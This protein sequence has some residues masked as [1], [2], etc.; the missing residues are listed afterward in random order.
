MISS[1]LSTAGS[2]RPSRDNPAEAM[3]E[4]LLATADAL[5]AAGAANHAEISRGLAAARSAHEDGLPTDLLE[6]MARAQGHAEEQL[7]SVI[8]TLGDAVASTLPQPPPLIPFAGKLIAPTTF[9]EN[10]GPIGKLAKLLLSPVLYAEDTDAIGVGSINV[11]AA[12][13]LAEEISK[14]TERR[15]GIRPFIS[16]V[17]L[18][19]ESWTFLC[20]KHFAR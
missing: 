6:C 5:H 19:Y 15:F 16:I 8:A 1:Y 20:R 7:A 14:T 3:E 11:V 17:R 4:S 18:D 13:I 10:N 9:Y 12:S 2:V